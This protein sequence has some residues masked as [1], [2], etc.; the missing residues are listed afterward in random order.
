MD[1]NY[2]VICGMYNKA[3]KNMSKQITS[4]MT[5]SLGQKQKFLKLMTEIGDGWYM[6]N[7]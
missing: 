1:Q 2:E 3:M 4:T 7:C 6:G 5:K